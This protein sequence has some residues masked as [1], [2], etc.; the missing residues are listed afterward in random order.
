ML[1]KLSIKQKLI[2]IMSIPLFVVILLSVKLTIE[3]FNHNTALT[4]LEKVVVLSTK[5]GALVHE[6][7]KER[8]M[9]AGFLGSK[10]LKFKTELP[11]QRENTSNRL[12]ELKTFLSGFDSKEYGK[13]FNTD[14]EDALNRLS[15]LSDIRTN[16]SSL[17]IQTAKAIGFYTNTNSSL[18]N[19]ISSITK[20]SNDAKISQRIIGYMNFL[21]SK[22]RAGI[23]RAVGTNTFARDN[24]GEGMKAK[25]YTLI[26]AQ[27]SYMDAFAKVVD[28]DS[29]KFYKD[30]VKGSSIDEVVKM[31]KIALYSNKDAEFNVD[32]SYW[33]SEITKKINLL[34]EVENYLAQKL[35]NEIEDRKSIANTEM[36]VYGLLSLFGIALTLI[37]ARTIA[38]T[39]ILDVDLVKKGLSDFFAFINFEK[40][41]INFKIIE[42]DDELGLMSRIIHENVEKTKLHIKSDRKLIAN[43][44]EVANRINKG[45]L[46]SRIEVDSNNP[47]L[48]NLKNIINEMLDTLN[49]NIQN[50]MTVLSSYSKLD[51]RPKLEDNHLEGIIKE[52]E[53]DVN[54]LGKVITETLIENKRSG[55][56]LSQ[57]A[58][59]LSKNMDS[60]SEAANNQAAS[61][62][63]TAASLEEITSNITSS[64]ETTLEMANYG[65]KVK[66]SI[67]QG[68]KQADDTAKAMTEINEQTSAI[69][70]AITVIDQIA[71][72]TN[73]L[74]LN[75]AVEAATAGEA[76]KGFAVVAQ[77]VRNLASRSAEA[78]KEI[79]SLVENA[80]I[81]A[82]EGKNIANSM[83]LGYDE[84][85]QNITKTIEL[86]ENVTMASKEQSTGIVQINDAVNNLDKITQQNAANA[87]EADLIAQKTLE[88]SN[89]IIT[90]ADAKE[91]NG[92][93]S[94][95]IRKAIQDDNYTGVERRETS[96]KFTNNTK[97]VNKETPKRSTNKSNHNDDWES[98]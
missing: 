23:E 98:F 82:N 22:E 49:S 6:T 90:H 43:T 68:Q 39:I 35:T 88:I 59:I 41:D 85:N 16:V 78:A 63:E 58:D 38:F 32:P 40:D 37:L 76:G 64:T 13:Q 27:N 56:I 17:N 72:Q 87:A 96:K 89:M 46:D 31:R 4:K 25:F 60:I 86:I 15:N 36:I 92:K 94:I 14:L 95:K 67:T 55:M 73:I 80:N 20:L 52:L 30:T 47:S 34:K 69:N 11:N 26:A 81:K 74:S 45:Y 66:I 42:S 54:G 97:T 93:E 10:G 5:I 61:L 12:V 1:S 48:N 91:F 19:V 84:L 29:Q 18:L 2:L 24:F 57:N 44:I 65:N 7:Q 8:G 75:A 21:L 77:E 3:L 51:F 79:K 62:E 28:E 71:F 83:I 9:T 50:T 53:T 33:F 70:E